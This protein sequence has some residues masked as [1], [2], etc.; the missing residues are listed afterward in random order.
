MPRD[1]PI[2][3]GSLLVAFDSHGPF[4]LPSLRRSAL[5]S[6]TSQ[7]LPFVLECGLGDV[8]WFPPA[9]GTLADQHRS[10]TLLTAGA[11]ALSFYMAVERDRWAGGLL[12]PDGTPTPDAAWV[13]HLLSSLRA[14]DWPSLR[15]LPPVAIITSS[16][17][18]DLATAA[19]L[20][21]PITPAATALLHLPL[22]D[23]SD[24]P[25][26]THLWLRAVE[27]AL[28]RAGIPYDVLDDSTPPATLASYRALIAPFT[29]HIPAGL[30]ATLRDLA[31]SK[32]TIVVLGP[33]PPTLDEANAP[34]P[35]LPLRRTGKMRPGSLTDLEGL[36]ADLTSLA[37]PSPT[38]RCPTD[39][40][41]LS[42]F[43]RATTPVALFLSNDGPATTATLVTTE[44]A[45]L[46]CALTSEIILLPSG[47]ASIP[48]AASSIRFFLI[49][50]P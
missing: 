45:T 8:P 3:N 18:A 34:L 48:L 11:R 31:E 14:L 6:L 16:L 27:L 15:R 33:T 42:L 20:L 43:F 7:P 19:S 10:L 40:C 47:S 46:R 25:S 39:S 9:G 5:R 49:E 28:E 21:D 26:T 41:T 37:G 30:L 44:P 50:R 1:L 2:G 38:W 35:P 32:R 22:S 29:T 4:D 24:L 36:A 13:T 23:L 12:S 17:D